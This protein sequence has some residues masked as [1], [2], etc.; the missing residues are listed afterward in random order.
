MAFG[1]EDWN[2]QDI[3]EEPNENAKRFYR[4]LHDGET[5]L[6]PGCEKFLKLSFIVKLLHIKILG[7]WSNKSFTILFELLKETLSSGET[8]PKSYYETNKV[9]RDL[10]LSYENIDV[11]VNDCVLF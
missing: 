9:I 7:G 5:K 11:C 3:D 6:Y 1:S 2:A 8:L 10:G 4:L